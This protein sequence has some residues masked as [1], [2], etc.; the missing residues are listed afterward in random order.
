VIKTKTFSDVSVL[1]RNLSIN[2]ENLTYRYTPNSAPVLEDI[3][4]KLN[5]GDLVSLTGPPGVGKTTL[6]NCI[7][8][9]QT[10]EY[11]KFEISYQ[12]T[13]KYS[14]SVLRSLISYS[15]QTRYIFDGTIAENIAVYS[16][17]ISASKILKTLKDYDLW[18]V[19]SELPKGLETHISNTSSLS[20]TLKVYIHLA[21]SL[22]RSPNVMIIDDIFLTLDTD[23]SQKLLTSISR[24]ASIVLFVSKEPSLISIAN[25]S[26]IL[27]PSGLVEISPR[28]L[29]SKLSGNTP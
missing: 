25:R 22:V 26:L 16:Q 17:S 3:S 11:H 6:L 1:S 29:Q 21:R 8:T 18:D 15:T 12:S 10:S 5:A 23:I 7:S 2:I 4:L 14:L 9:L 24:L 19:F 28:I 20:N 27:S 13:N